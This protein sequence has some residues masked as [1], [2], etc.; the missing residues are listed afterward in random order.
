LNTVYIPDGVDDAAVRGKL[1]N[2]DNL[3][4]ATCPGILTGKVWCIG[5]MGY[6]SNEKT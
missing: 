3:E 1:L 2:G 5:L 4:T 6:A